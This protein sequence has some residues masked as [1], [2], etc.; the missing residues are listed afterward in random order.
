MTHDINKDVKHHKTINISN[1]P[2]TLRFREMKDIFT[3]LNIELT[4]QNGDR[5]SRIARKMFSEMKRCRERTDDRSKIKVII[6]YYGAT[7]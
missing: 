5:Q 3:I 4:S 2:S 7:E 1:F 6:F